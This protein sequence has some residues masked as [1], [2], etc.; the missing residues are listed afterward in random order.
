MNTFNHDRGE[1]ID[2]ATRSYSTIMPR[3][4]P[5][6]D[7]QDGP[8][9]HLSQYTLS[10]SIPEL[11]S[12][13]APIRARI[14]VQ[15]SQINELVKQRQVLERRH[16]AELGSYEEV[17]QGLRKEVKESEDWKKKAGE[18][19]RIRLE[20]EAMRDEVSLVLSISILLSRKLS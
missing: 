6:M 4:Q 5:P 15:Q 9:N 17:V 20:G 10:Q 12:T 3:S 16:K 13:P 8:N 11:P 2:S 14:N 1:T 18:I 19:D 7:T